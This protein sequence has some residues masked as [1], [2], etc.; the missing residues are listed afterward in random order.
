MGSMAF[1]TG[2]GRLTPKMITLLI[3]RPGFIMAAPAFLRHGPGI[4]GIAIF[5]KVM[6]GDTLPGPMDRFFIL[7]FVNIQ[8]N[9]LVISGHCQ[10]FLAMTLET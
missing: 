5:V 3:I 6:T 7:R 4:G 2:W 10:F 1:G 8:G 9:L